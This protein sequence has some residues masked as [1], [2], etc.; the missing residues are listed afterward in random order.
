MEKR[1]KLCVYIDI[2]WNDENPF[3]AI[4]INSD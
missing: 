1:N 2:L 4:L 3:I